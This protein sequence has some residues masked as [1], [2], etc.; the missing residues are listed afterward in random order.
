MIRFS[1]LC[2]RFSRPSARRS[3]PNRRLPLMRFAG[4]AMALSLPLWLVGCSGED[5]TTFA[6]SCP[7]MHIPAEV[8]DYYNYSAKGPSFNHLV[9][10]ASITK[11]S[12]DCLAAGKKTL[13]TRV[14]IRMLVRR[15]PGATS[16]EFVFPWFLAVVHNDKIV[17]K[18][19]FSQTVTFPSGQDA[20]A[21]DTRLV[22]VDLP[23]RPTTD[24]SDYHF[25]VGFQLS[26]TQLAYNREHGILASFDAQ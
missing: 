2:S 25:E 12:G 3:F 5:E 1:S 26:H 22:T 24:A 19:V 10:H 11:L 18:H 15:G 13:R 7:A 23:I 17:G 14:A 21:V 8:G 20:M 6:P 4:V 9:T 16:D